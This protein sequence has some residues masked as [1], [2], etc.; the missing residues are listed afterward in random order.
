MMTDDFQ[1]WVNY[2]LTGPGS[3][4][5]GQGGV[6]SGRVRWGGGSTRRRTE[7]RDETPG[8]LQTASQDSQ[9]SVVGG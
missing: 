6:E 5:L 9:L 2:P 4:V 8:E 3:G 1:F 7:A